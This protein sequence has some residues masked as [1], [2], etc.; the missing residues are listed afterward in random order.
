MAL[1]SKKDLK[2]I[3]EYYY[4]AGNKSWYPFP[5][6]LKKRLLSVY[7][8]APFPH[9]WTEQDISEGTRKIIID[10]FNN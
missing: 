5:K 8:K 6:E 3:E 10:Y 7:G 4:L 1:L 9:D 2:K